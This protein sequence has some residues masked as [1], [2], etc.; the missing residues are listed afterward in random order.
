VA[1]LL[2]IFLAARLSFFA[3][4][5]LHSFSAARSCFAFVLVIDFA[6]AQ[7]LCCTLPLR[8]DSAA[9]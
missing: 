6:D 1:S 8:H 9:V 4:P 5:L 3:I 2:S 7:I